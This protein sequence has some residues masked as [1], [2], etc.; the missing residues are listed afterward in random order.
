MNAKTYTL[1]DMEMEI[2][3]RRNDSR[4]TGTA[5]ATIKRRILDNEY[6]PGMQIPEQVLADSL[7]ISR[8][9]AREALVRLA[10]EGLIEII[11]R[12]G[13]RVLPI[14]AGDMKEI[15][16]VLVSLEPMATELL[17]LKKPQ[18][19]DVA[20]LTE[21]CDEMELALEADDLDAWA[22][23]DEKFHF[24]LVELCGNRRLA[25]MVMAVWE[26][27]HRARMITLK[28]RPK[29]VESTREHR[30]VVEAILA[31][32]VAV[33]RELYREHRSKA[34]N[35]MIGIIEKMGMNHL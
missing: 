16:E 29:P 24:Q 15:Y 18:R 26:Q 9:P 11:P 1:A 23:A 7:G 12:H 30:A 20:G 33:A 27:S 4:S 10:Q 22:R 5:Y 28:L 31:G 8:T 32:D 3:E 34:A 19:S 14:S 17:A 35:A 2:K 13:M 25:N 6:A 21:A